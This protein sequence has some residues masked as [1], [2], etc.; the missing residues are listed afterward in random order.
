M[1]TGKEKDYVLGIRNDDGTFEPIGGI[2]N[3]PDISSPEMVETSEL[4]D[5]QKEW[6]VTFS[7]EPPKTHRELREFIEVVQSSLNYVIW[8]MKT[9]GCNNWRK[10]H[11]LP[12]MRKVRK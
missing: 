2:I 8:W 6:E 4:P 3:Y 10:I 5:F 1:P 7:L 9:Y 11:K 12:L